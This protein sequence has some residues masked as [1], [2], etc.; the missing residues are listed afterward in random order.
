MLDT[1]KDIDE[2]IEK[3]KNIRITENFATIMFY[4]CDKTCRHCT[5]QYIL[6]EE[7]V[8]NEKE[9]KYGVLTNDSYDTCLLYLE[10][11]EGY[12]KGKKKITY[13]NI[14][15]DRFVVTVDAIR[16]MNRKELHETEIFNIL[17]LTKYEDTKWQIV[18]EPRE[19]KIYYKSQRVNQLQVIDMKKIDFQNKI[20]RTVMNI[21]ANHSE[22]EMFDANRNYELME[23]FFRN[24]RVSIINRKNQERR[25]L[26]MAQYV[27]A[28]QE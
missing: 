1:C 18:Y 24:L 26:E 4:V 22:F 19:Q 23:Q 14:S 10:Q 28:L 21:D 12:G 11:H 2:V 17:D 13:T 7:Q 8:I 15:I 20:I 9:L 5:I 27:K 6:G 25:L 16:K 3:S